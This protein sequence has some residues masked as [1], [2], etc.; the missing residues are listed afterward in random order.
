MKMLQ[1][2][3]RYI[4]I[5]LCLLAF[6]IRL[7][8]DMT[9]FSL[10]DYTSYSTYLQSIVLALSLAV[11]FVIIRSN[12]KSTAPYSARG[13]VITCSSITAAFVFL[14]VYINPEGLFPWNQLPVHV[15]GAARAAKLNLYGRL[16][17]PPEIVLLGSSRAHMLPAS[18]VRQSFNLPAFNWSV[19]GGG[20]V[21]ALTITNFLL[22]RQKAPDVLVVEITP[23]LYTGA[24]QDRTPITMLPYL[25]DRQQTLD[26]FQTEMSNVLSYRMF[27]EASFTYLYIY[28]LYLNNPGSFQADG[29]SV[30][31]APVVPWPYRDA[32]G[33]EAPQKKLELQCNGPT[34]DGRAYTERLTR[35]ADQQKFGIVF[36][37]SPLNSDFLR[38]FDLGNPAV[39]NCLGQIDSYMAHLTQT[40]PNMRYLNLLRYDPISNLRAEGYV[41]I[42]HIN[43][44]AAERLMDVLLPEISGALQWAVTAR[45]E[46]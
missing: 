3:W 28:R 6:L 8:Q 38:K 9:R 37:I 21:D 13:W 17:E 22:A 11:L 39:E 5:A 24:W 7:V 31:D 23:D 42:E 27:S 10:T 36:Y 2:F 14:A 30:G 43:K 18:Y 12:G 46:K 26:A 32:L 1:R 34:S 20:A 41:D 4:G 40:H 33:V 35:M 16:K 15:V 29:T 45:G 25:P 19:E 44:L